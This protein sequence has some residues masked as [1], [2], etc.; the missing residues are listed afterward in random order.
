MKIEEIG[1]IQQI[2]P[3]GGVSVPRTSEAD[4][5]TSLWTLVESMNETQKTAQNSMQDVVSGKSDDSAGALVAL[6]KASL[7]LEI[8]STVRDKAV[9]A[10]NKLMDTQI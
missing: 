3:V 7:Q 1:M 10:F 9:Y 8:A 6:E 4:F 2:A 5:T